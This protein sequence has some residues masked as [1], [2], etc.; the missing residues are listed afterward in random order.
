IDCGLG[1][2]DVVPNLGS[3]KSNKQPEDDAERWQ[4]AGG[5][6]L[7]DAGPFSDGDCPDERENSKSDQVGCRE[8]NDNHPNNRKV[9][10]PSVQS[11][12]PLCS[13]AKGKALGVTKLTARAYFRTPSDRIPGCVR[14]FNS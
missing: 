13:A 1:S 5:N 14:P 4:H 3:N 7:E 6:S 10:N 2:V 11:C 8:Y 12:S 9:M